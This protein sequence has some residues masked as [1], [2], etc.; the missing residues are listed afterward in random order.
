MTS[1]TRI[2]KPRKI[3]APRKTTKQV[4]LGEVEKIDPDF[5]AIYTQFKNMPF[6]A[7]QFLR[8]V[9]GGICKS[10][11]YRRDIGYVDIPWGDPDEDSGYGLAHI[12]A[13]HEKELAQL[14][15]TVEGMIQL[16]FKFG[17]KDENYRGTK[18]FL[19]GATYRIIL[20]TEWKNKSHSTLLLSAFDLRPI[21]QKN[22]Q[23]AKKLAK[24]KRAK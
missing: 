9:K 15:Q 12:I 4:V 1:R 2:S 23:R 14:H 16:V 11:L 19:D 8:S 18:I 10:A 3:S 13:V 20:T 7:M 24:R 5:G 21:A 6:E 22:P 17:V